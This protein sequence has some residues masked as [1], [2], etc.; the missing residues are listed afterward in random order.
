MVMISLTVKS[1]QTKPY[2]SSNSK[3]SKKKII[4][5]RVK[6]NPTNDVILSK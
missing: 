1:N 6:K 5:K 2:I 3:M 4:I